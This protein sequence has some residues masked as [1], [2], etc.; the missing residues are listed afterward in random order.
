[1]TFASHSDV[2]SREVGCEAF[3]CETMAEEVGREG[4]ESGALYRC[5]SACC[6][7]DPFSAPL[8]PLLASLSLTRACIDGNEEAA[9][10]MQTASRRRKESI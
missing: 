5:P 8:S 4:L 7:G 10:H 2:S 6:S 1:M 9:A 3:A